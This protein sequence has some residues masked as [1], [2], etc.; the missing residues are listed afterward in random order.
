MDGTQLVQLLSVQTGNMVASH[1]ILLMCWKE[2]FPNEDATRFDLVDELYTIK[3]LDYI[4]ISPQ[5]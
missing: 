5:Y 4:K 3:S 1:T 2:I